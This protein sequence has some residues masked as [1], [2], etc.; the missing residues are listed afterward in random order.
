MAFSLTQ[1]HHQSPRLILIPSLIALTAFG[2]IPWGELFSIETKNHLINLLL[3]GLIGHIGL[4]ILMTLM[5]IIIFN[6]NNWYSGLALLLFP[7]VLSTGVLITFVWTISL[8][9]WQDL[10]VYSNGKQYLI[11]EHTTGLFINDIKYRFIVSNSISK[12]V[13]FIQ[14][15]EVVEDF[16]KDFNQRYIVYNGLTWKKACLNQENIYVNLLKM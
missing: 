4:L 7:I 9:E 6:K 2:Y 8:T 1:L 11:L 5:F 3:N 14:N 12:S 15:V 10:N 16:P 13:R